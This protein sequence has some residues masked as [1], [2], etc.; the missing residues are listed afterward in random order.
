LEEGII[1]IQLAKMPVVTKCH[2]EDDANC[3]G[4]DDWAECGMKI[5]AR[6]LSKAFCNQAR[7][8]SVDGPIRISLDPEKP[9]AGYNVFGRVR[10]NK[11]PSLIFN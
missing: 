5:N 9:L 8:V 7:F 10:R 2:R 1:D 11:F 6:P 4:L 3:G